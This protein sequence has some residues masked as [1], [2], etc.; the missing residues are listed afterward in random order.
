M[1][2]LDRLRMLHD[3]AERLSSDLP[4]EEMFLR[5]S[6]EIVAAISG[7]IEEVEEAEGNG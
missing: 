5:F 2:V 6:E 4:T 3:A 1:S 7:Y